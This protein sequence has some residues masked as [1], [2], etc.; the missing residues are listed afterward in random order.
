MLL[1]SQSFRFLVLLLFVLSCASTKSTHHSG[2]KP[3]FAKIHF[4]ENTTLTEAIELAKKED[5]PIFIDI[6]TDWCLP[7]KVM[8]EEVYSDRAISRYFNDNFINLKANGDEDIGNKLAFLF[9]V[10]G[11]PSLIFVD[12]RGR[13][14]LKHTGGTSSMKF[15]QLGEKSL[16]IFQER[17]S[18]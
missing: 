10:K 8:E 4:L 18:S 1:F 15:L 9:E 6:Y 2:E 5:K 3:D 16:S 12:H 13:L 14:I 7:C 17:K 11:Y